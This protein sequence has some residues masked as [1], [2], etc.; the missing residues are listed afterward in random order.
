MAESPTK[1]LLKDCPIASNETQK[2][3]FFRTLGKVGDI[4]ALNNVNGEIGEG[5]RALETI[6]NQLR[7]GQGAPGIFSDFGNSI[8]NGANAVLGA[9]GIDPN[10]ARSLGE[11]F[12]PGVLN[13]ATGQ[14]EQIYERVQQG[15]FE[16][17][18]VPEAIQDFGNL[19]QL[20]KGVFTPARQ[21]PTAKKNPSECP[22]S[23]YAVDLINLAPKHKFMF[24]VEF[25]FSSE[26]QAQF[27]EQ[28]V[29]DFAF[30][31][32]RTT[33]PNMNFEYEDINYYN[34][35]TKLLKKSEYQPMTMTFYDDMT[36]NVLRFYTRYMQIISPI[37]RSVGDGT[38]TMFEES[39]MT[40]DQ[41]G[42]V[43]SAS[44]NAISD[45]TKTI[46][47]YVNLY[48]IVHAGRQVDVYRFDN[49][50]LQTMTLDELDMADGA[51]GTE[52][53]VEFNYD[54]LNIQPGQDI[55]EFTNLQQSTSVGEYPIAPRFAGDEPTLTS[56]NDTNP[57]TA[58]S[59]IDP[60]ALAGQILNA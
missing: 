28:G 56:P 27:N 13:R 22:P 4:E 46:I 43:N 9:V 59:S 15:N 51:T 23:P 10:A 30:V 54:G 21:A 53:A 40:F 48:H 36:D 19:S 20:I 58:T 16:V 26:F 33:R 14:A 34:F 57:A 55:R 37:S 44:I 41:G 29:K 1:F 24:V 35:R 50:R 60:E 47:D 45:T 32:K 3:S 12:N 31:I 18:D 8:E 49:P 5:L 52:I 7:L 38:S 17:R 25:V 11:R 39:G 6:S 42:G 2:S